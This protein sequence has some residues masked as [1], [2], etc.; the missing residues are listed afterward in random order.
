LITAKQP[1]PTAS[2][3]KQKSLVNFRPS[4]IIEESPASPMGKSPAK[5]PAKPA[6]H[7]PSRVPPAAPRMYVARERE[8]KLLEKQTKAMYSEL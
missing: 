6:A 4:K 5:S 2:P 8:I 7:S 1:N 3:K